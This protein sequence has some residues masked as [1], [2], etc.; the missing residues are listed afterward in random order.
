MKTNIGFENENPVF[1]SKLVFQEVFQEIREK[2][3]IR[4]VVLRRPPK[5]VEAIL[6][7]QCFVRLNVF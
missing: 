3:E 7:T 6:K 4:R 1:F 5:N 2:R